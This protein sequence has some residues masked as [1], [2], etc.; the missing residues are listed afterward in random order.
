M[1]LSQPKRFSIGID[2][3]KE[4]GIGVWDRRVNRLL[5]FTSTNF[6]G[7]YPWLK[8]TVVLSQSRVFVEVAGKFLY[9][10]HDEH[11]VKTREQ[12]ILHAGGVRREGQLL[13]A[14]LRSYRIETFG[15]SPIPQKKWTE[16][17]FQMICKTTRS[18]NEHQRDAARLAMAYAD[19]REIKEA[20]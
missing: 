7:V 12:I 4:T 13:V 8:K 11:N 6:I 19:R 1:K 15:V 16:A 2:V 5:F 9:G 14:L 17:Q 20:K 18:A 3:G 10:R